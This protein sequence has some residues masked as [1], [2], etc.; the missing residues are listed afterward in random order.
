[1]D[2]VSFGAL[3]IPLTRT[4]SEKYLIEKYGRAGAVSAKTLAKLACVGGGPV[5]CRIGRRI[6]YL[7]SD[8]DAWVKSR[9][10]GPLINTGTVK[11]VEIPTQP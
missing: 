1:M 7:P 4:E 2:P 5:F 3:E 6:A 8:L 10:S 11:A 9:S